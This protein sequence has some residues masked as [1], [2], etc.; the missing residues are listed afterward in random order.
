MAVNFQRVQNRYTFTQKCSLLFSIDNINNFMWTMEAYMDDG[1]LQM[2]IIW[3]AVQ[4]G[5]EGQ[6][7]INSCINYIA[8]KARF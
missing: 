4:I 7:E 3:H 5:C 8:E 1:S 6:Q 2:T